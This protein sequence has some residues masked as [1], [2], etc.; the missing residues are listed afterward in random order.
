MRWR[1]TGQRGTPQGGA[2]SPLLANIYLHPFDVALTSQGVRLV[3][4]VDDFVV[5]C[6]SEDEARHTLT[7]VERQL[8]ALHLELNHDKTRIVNYADGLEFL[9]QALAPI[10]R[11][12]RWIEGVASFDEAQ[13]RLRAT[14]AQIRR[15]VKRSER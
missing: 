11:G 9:G 3:R 15:K 4:F 7:L 8:S 10:R 13:E 12:P 1:Q 6:A 2:L 5:L 14:T